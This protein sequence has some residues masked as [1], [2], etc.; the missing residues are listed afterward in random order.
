MILPV[1]L[2]G[3]GLAAL[4]NI[5]LGMRCGQVRM[6]EKINIGDGGNDAL[7]RRMRAQANF[8]ENVPIF[9]VLLG[10]IEYA[11]GTSTWLWAVMALFMLARVAHALGMDG[12][13][14]EKGRGI[15]IMVTMLSILGLAL[16]AIALPHVS[17]GQIEETPAD[18]V[19]QG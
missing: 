13:A 7:I 1:S 2:T 18:V 8:I 6:R 3:A 15:G 17:N 4:I 14:A 9:L 11:A 12:G 5:W 19:P 10:L 16:Y